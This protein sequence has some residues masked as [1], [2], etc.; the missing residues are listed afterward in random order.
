[1][2]KL[3]IGDMYPAIAECAGADVE[4]EVVPVVSAFVDVLAG[5]LADGNSVGIVGL[6]SLLVDGNNVVFSPSRRLLKEL[7]ESK[8]C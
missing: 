1:M 8:S 4:D 5:T 3:W 6:G 7:R 2:K